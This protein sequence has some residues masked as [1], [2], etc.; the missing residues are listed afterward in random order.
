M[1]KQSSRFILALGGSLLA[2][3][4]AAYDCTTLAQYQNGSS[5]ANNQKSKK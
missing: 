4:A 5:Y 2:G 1:I 3:Y